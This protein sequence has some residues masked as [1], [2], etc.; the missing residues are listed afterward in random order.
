MPDHMPERQCD[1]GGEN[2]KAAHRV[3]AGCARAGG[4]GACAALHGSTHARPEDAP[5]SR[6]SRRPARQRRAPVRRQYNQS[7]K[8]FHKFS[9]RGE[10]TL[11]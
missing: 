8:L 1:Q 6:R 2:K 11:L 3:G 9:N 7:A 4:G 10:A 5:W